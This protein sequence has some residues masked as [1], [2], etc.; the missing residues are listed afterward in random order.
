MADSIT[1]E[2]V[3]EVARLAKLQLPESEIS[4]YQQHLSRML[5]YLGQ[6]ARYPCGEEVQPFFGICETVNA[7]RSDQVV[8][9][10]PQDLM[11]ANAAE[12]DE[13]FYLVPKVLE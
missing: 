10:Y 12:T 6:I 13:Q 8:A 9:S 2:T 3:L 7:V 1:R 5:D 11:L 4:A